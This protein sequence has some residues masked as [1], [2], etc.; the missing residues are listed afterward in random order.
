MEIKV[1]NWA[2]NVHCV[3]AIV[4]DSGYYYIGSTKCFKKRSIIHK[5]N[6]ANHP[7]VFGIG[8]THNPT[9][10]EMFVLRLSYDY[11]L[12]LNIEKHLLILNSKDKFLLNKSKVN[13]GL[14]KL[15]KTIC[16]RINKLKA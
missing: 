5:C 12:V 4:F 13:S 11:Y 2:E 9:K 1:E 6:L 3:Y 7:E 15:N 16:K 10:C 14:E 8:S